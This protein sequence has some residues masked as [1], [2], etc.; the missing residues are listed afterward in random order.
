VY[1]RPTTDG[2]IEVFHQ[3]VPVPEVLDPDLFAARYRPAEPADLL[4][5]AVG[6]GNGAAPARTS[7]PQK[8]GGKKSGRKPQAAAKAKVGGRA[9]KWDVEQA[10]RLYLA[11]TPYAEV[12][13]AVG[14]SVKALG[15]YASKHGWPKERKRLG[16]SPRP[17]RPAAA[18]TLAD[19]NAD[20]AKFGLSV[21]TTCWNCKEITTNPRECHLCGADEPHRRAGD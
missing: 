4:E 1:T 21:I 20:R 13:A 8:R 18:P 11:G 5:E 14:C 17:G 2:R 16:T 7:S 10:H 6:S 12:A 9:P 3:G 19:V 15:V